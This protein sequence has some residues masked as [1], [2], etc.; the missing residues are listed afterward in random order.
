MWWCVAD[1]ASVGCPK[2]Q[3]REEA[4]PPERSHHAAG[5]DGKRQLQP[6]QGTTAMVSNDRLKQTSC[7]PFLIHLISARAAP[8]EPVLV[9]LADPGAQGRQ[10]ARQH[11]GV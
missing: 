7:K 10:R 11:S 9:P 1:V 4:P 3:D 5:H 6:I 2:L 8:A